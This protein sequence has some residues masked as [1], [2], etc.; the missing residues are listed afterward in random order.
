MDF[1]F[2]VF[3]EFSIFAQNVSITLHQMF[4]YIFSPNSIIPSHHL[5]NVMWLDTLCSVLGFWNREH[6]K[7]CDNAAATWES[8]LYCQSKLICHQIDPVVQ[9][10]AKI[11]SGWAN[12]IL[13]KILEYFTKIAKQLLVRHKIE[14]EVRAQTQN[15]LLK[16]FP[17]GQNILNILWSGWVDD[18]GLERRRAEEEERLAGKY[19]AQVSISVIMLKN[20]I[21]ITNIIAMV[22]IANTIIMIIIT[23][24][25]AFTTGRGRPGP[26]S[27]PESGSQRSQVN[28]PQL[29]H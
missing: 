11:L 15:I 19:P 17:C 28:K 21:T 18:S 26:R 4:L 6:L 8:R 12:D 13:W 14:K 23:F 16:I 5:I 9:N 2:G 3:D 24:Q 27:R 7:A 29:I 1:D 22:I 10:F 25:G 20:I